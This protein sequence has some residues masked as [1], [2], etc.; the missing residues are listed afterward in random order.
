MWLM[1]VSVVV[2]NFIWQGYG[3]DMY[4]VFS[5]LVGKGNS[6]AKCKVWVLNSDKG[7]LKWR[8]IFEANNE[9]KDQGVLE[10]THF[11]NCSE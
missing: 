10:K 7:W 9:E 3:S 5:W 8:T 1:S 4:S 11:H 6:G 2:S